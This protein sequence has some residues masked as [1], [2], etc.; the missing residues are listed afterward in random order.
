MPE[1]RKVVT[2]EVVLVGTKEVATILG[3][4]K[5]RITQLADQHRDFPRPLACLASG[6]VF[7]ALSVAEFLRSW[8]RRPGRPPKRRTVVKE[9]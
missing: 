7:C 2:G 9:G 5:Q 6:P 3:V 4:S 1:P 8:D